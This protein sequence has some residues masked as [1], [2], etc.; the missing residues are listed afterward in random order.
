MTQDVTCYDTEQKKH[1]W[2]CGRGCGW[3]RGHGCG[4]AR[5]DPARPDMTRDMTQDGGAPDGGGR[6][7]APCRA[8]RTATLSRAPMP[9]C[10][11]PCAPCSAKAPALSPNNALYPSGFRAL[12]PVPCP[13]LQPSPSPWPLAPTP[14]PCPSTYPLAL[15]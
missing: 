12:C 7:C 2:G 8:P 4:R 9:A 1:G 6:P 3:G 14:L 13:S 5:H 10:P 15:P 11:V